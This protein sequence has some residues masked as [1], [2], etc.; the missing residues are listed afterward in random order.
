[1]N[2]LRRSPYCPKCGKKPPIRRTSVGDSAIRITHR[3][4]CGVK[5]EIATDELEPD[6]DVEPE[7]IA[8]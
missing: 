5:Y 8:G 1:M 4:R 2:P 3:C 6:A 7:R